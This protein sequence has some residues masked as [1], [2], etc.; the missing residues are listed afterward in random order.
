MKNFYRN[1]LKLCSMLVLQNVVTLSVNLA[2]NIMLGAFSETAL[3]GVTTV[4]QV[5]F[6]FQQ[7]LMALGDGL[8]IFGSQ[9]W[10]KKETQPVRKISAWAMRTGLFIALILFILASF[11]PRQLLGLFTTDQTIIEAG[12]SYLTIIRFTY[13][14]FAITQILLS[15]LRCVEIAGIAFALSV[16]TL[17]I[18]CTINW[19]LI[20]GHFGAPGMGAAGAAVG[21][22]T[23]RIV[24]IC[25]LIIYISRKQGWIGIRLKDYLKTDWE[26]GWKYYKVVCPL[27]VIQGLWGVN[28]ALQTVILG[29]MTAAAIAANSAA[30]NLFLMVKSAAVGA[31]S[32][33][34]VTMGKTIGSGDLDLAKLYSRKLQKLFVVM[35]L[36]CGVLL[37][38]IR[39]PVLSL[40]QLSPETRNM[41]NTFLIILSVV[42]VG[43]SYQMPTNGGIIRG[44][45]SIAYSM[46]VDLI[47]TWVVVI[48]LSAFVAFMVKASP[49]VVVCCLNADQIFKCVPAF[50]K[51]NYGHWIK[52]M[53]N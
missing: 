53:T 32:A 26:F 25:V 37:F 22:L 30:S 5:Q 3:S 39:I 4:N 13:F 23:A 31:A 43:M 7:L 34:S 28:T 48:P 20:Y 45:G 21:T 17:V 35:G 33:A 14:F 1:F 15:T 47:S 10:G 51:C 11:F 18:N 49:A 19:I 42:M 16:M 44:S 46:K 52:N 36:T 40:Y 29:H 12:M 2:D 8:V 24:E 38:F 9:Y 50:I 27:L 6:V 41:A